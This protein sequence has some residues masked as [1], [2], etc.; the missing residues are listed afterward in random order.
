M[1][2]TPDPGTAIRARLPALRRIPY[3][4][5]ALAIAALAGFLLPFEGNL[6]V[7]SFPSMARAFDVPPS[8]VVWTMVASTLM[9]VGLALPIA[10]LSERCF[11]QCRTGDP[12]HHQG[13]GR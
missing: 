10:V 13:R 5:L 1:T 6:V 12:Q 9:T 7:V 11:M 8:D 2:N 3:P 4:W